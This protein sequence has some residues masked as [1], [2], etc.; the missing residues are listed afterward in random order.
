MSITDKAGVNAASISTGELCCRITGGEGAASL[1]TVIPT[2]VGV[3]A[4]VAERD[5]ASVVTGEVNGSTSMEGWENT[6]MCWISFK[7][8][9]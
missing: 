9:Y 3:V 1:V 6:T 5:T 8:W 2:V 4:G 7:L